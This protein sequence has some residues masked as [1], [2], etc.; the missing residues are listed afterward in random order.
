MQM[1]T[2]QLFLHRRRTNMRFPDQYLQEMNRK[3]PGLIKK[4]DTVTNPRQLAGV[5]SGNSVSPSDFNRKYAIY[6]WSKSRVFFRFSVSLGKALFDDTDTPN[7][8]VSFLRNLPTPSVAVSIRPLTIVDP[9]TR[10]ATAQY[11]GN[12]FIWI[13]AAGLSSA[14]ETTEGEWVW[15]SVDLDNAERYE[16]CFE[17]L[18]ETQLRTNGIRDIAM[19]KRLLGVEYFRDI[20]GITPR[21]ISRFFNKFGERGRDAVMN[22]LAL[23]NIKGVLLQEMCFAVL[24]LNCENADVTEA[25]P[26]T[27]LLGLHRKN[28]EERSRFT[29]VDETLCWVSA[30]KETQEE[31]HMP[32]GPEGNAEGPMEEQSEN[33]ESLR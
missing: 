8:P 14:W 31:K 2:W 17:N 3:Y 21:H 22:A 30:E 28:S 16:D 6:Q 1:K 25:A 23:S 20:K 15:L 11:T 19:V 9:E 13:D 12:A 32:R 26:G 7:V 4:L 27:Y 5:L 10:K 18:V 29:V 33:Q 24:Y